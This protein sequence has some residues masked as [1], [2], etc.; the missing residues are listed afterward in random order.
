MYKFLM[1]SSCWVICKEKNYIH[2]KWI[3]NTT[4]VFFFML[5]TKKIRMNNEIGQWVELKTIRQHFG[6]ICGYFTL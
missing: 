2:R 3:K 6:V 5:I 1:L 4:K